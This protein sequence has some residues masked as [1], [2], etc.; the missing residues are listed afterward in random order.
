M[1]TTLPSLYT[2]KGA[3]ALL[4]KLAPAQNTIESAST[5]PIPDI[6]ALGPDSLPRST[7]PVATLLPA[8]TVSVIKLVLV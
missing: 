3:V 8:I 6:P 7:L 2:L 5:V 1:A 4:V